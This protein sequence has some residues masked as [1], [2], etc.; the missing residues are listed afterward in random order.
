MNAQRGLFVDRVKH[1][2]SKPKLSA[3]APVI[4]PTEPAPKRIY[5]SN[6][7]IFGLYDGGTPWEYVEIKW[8]YLKPASVRRVGGGEL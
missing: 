8:R 6:G 4:L 2:H 7:L 1:P 3:A 5:E